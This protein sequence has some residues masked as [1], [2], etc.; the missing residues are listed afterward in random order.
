MTRLKG[1]YN[2]ATIK[3]NCVLKKSTA[4]SDACS[5]L[6]HFASVSLIHKRYKSEFQ[7]SHLSVQLLQLLMEKDSSLTPTHLAQIVAQTHFSE[8]LLNTVHMLCMAN[9]YHIY[10]T[11][12]F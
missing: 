5:H 9:V 7:L 4:I 1:Y 8:H 12:T 2:L 10:L 6:R 11:R 3:L